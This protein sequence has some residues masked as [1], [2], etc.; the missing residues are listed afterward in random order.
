MYKEITFNV[1]SF[2]SLGLR[3]TRHD[4][5]TGKEEYIGW[6]SG[7]PGS[8]VEEFT[9]HFYQQDE[10]PFSGVSLPKVSV[11]LSTAFDFGDSKY[12]ISVVEMRPSLYVIDPDN[13]DE[14][15]KL[16]DFFYPWTHM[17]LVVDLQNNLIVECNVFF[18]ED[19]VLSE[20]SHLFYIPKLN[21]SLLSQSEVLT[22]LFGYDGQVYNIIPATEPITFDR[23]T[24]V[25]SVRNLRQQAIG[26]IV[27]NIDI[28]AV[29]T[30]DKETFLAEMDSWWSIDNPLPLS[31]IHEHFLSNVTTKKTFAQLIESFLDIKGTVISKQ[32]Y[33]RWPIKGKD[34]I[35]VTFSNTVNIGT[36]VDTTLW[37]MDETYPEEPDEEYYPEDDD[38]HAEEIF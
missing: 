28:D 34:D 8:S 5:V 12:N 25:S 20:D 1:Y 19:Q 6:Y 3:G 16:P 37:T 31:R 2:E 7:N 13:T 26:E 4:P 23:T 27:Q 22:T 15:N 14:E 35:K 10:F 30:D 38:E 29:M 24:F 33:D 21:S 11:Y 32:D 9:K 18:S 17:V 36:I